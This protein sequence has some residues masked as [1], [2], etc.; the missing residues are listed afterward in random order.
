MRK[1]MTA[2]TALA[3]GLLLAPL[4]LGP[5][6]A[7][8][9]PDLK[10]AVTGIHGSEVTLVGHGGG[11]RGGGGGGRGDG[12]GRGGGGGGHVGN[13]GGNHAAF[14]GGSGRSFSGHVGGGRIGGGSYAYHGVRGGSGGYASYNGRNYSGSQNWHHGGN[15]NNW[16]SNNHHG[17][18]N[19]AGNN[20]HRGY[21]RYNRFYPYWYGS[22]ASYGYNY[23]NCYWLQQQ[24]LITGNAYWW[25][26]YNRCVGYY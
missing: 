14:S 8:S 25:N 12:G 4:M 1:S 19:W 9:A 15:G 26:R 21:Y 18:N 2:V 6:Q 23:G 13:F 24:A 5:T 16:G 17:G 10:N 22:Y 11:G 20:H 7:G 3:G